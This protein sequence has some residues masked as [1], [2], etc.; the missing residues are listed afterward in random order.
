MPGLAADPVVAR[1]LLERPAV[2]M[3]GGIDVEQV[4]E[5]VEEVVVGDADRVD[6]V[7]VAVGGV[8]GVVK[9]KAAVREAELAGVVV[10]TIR[11]A[12]RPTRARPS[13]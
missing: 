10:D 12:S 13:R 4:A 11:A 6:E 7:D 8:P 5:V 9:A 3:R 2:R 1:P